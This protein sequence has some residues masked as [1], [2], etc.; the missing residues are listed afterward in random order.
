MVTATSSR[1]DPDRIAS[2][3]ANGWRMYYERN[4]PRFAYLMVRLCQEQFHI[5]FPW[6]VLAAVNIVRA[7]AAW[8]GEL[9]DTKAALRS[10]ERYYGFVRRYSGYSFDASRAA[11][12]EL[13]YW[14]VHRRVVDQEDKSEFVTSLVLLHSLIFGIR[15][16]QARESAELRVQAST[17]VDRITGGRSSD[18][19]RDW[20][21]L[22]AHL[23]DT[24][25]SILRVL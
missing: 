8:F 16:D 25:R 22:E 5:P 23:R 20:Q 24:Y 4:W 14:D 3:E 11:Q 21:L 9:Q 18:Q 10:L 15:P 12:A 6:S 2:A 19:E 1:F 13:S 17:L 7:A